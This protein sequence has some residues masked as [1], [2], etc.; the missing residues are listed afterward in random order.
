MKKKYCNGQC[1]LDML[2]KEKDY[3]L[4]DQNEKTTRLGEEVK[5]LKDVVEIDAIDKSNLEVDMEYS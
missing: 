1:A 3:A 2:G 5:S 4:C